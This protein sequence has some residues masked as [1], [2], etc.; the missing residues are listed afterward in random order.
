MVK[1]SICSTWYMQLPSQKAQVRIKLT[2]AEGSEPR[3]WAVLQTECQSELEMSH[4]VDLRF[5]L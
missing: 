2:H 4:L 1:K 3:G 5:Q